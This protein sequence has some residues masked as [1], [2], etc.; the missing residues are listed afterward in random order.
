MLT[1]FLDHV[2]SFALARV[3]ITAIELDVFWHLEQT[4]LTRDNL[5]HRLAIMD[6]PIADAFLD[7][8]VAFQIIAEENDRLT[9][10]PLGKSVLSVYETIK[11]WNK[12]MSLFYSCLNDLT[13]VLRSGR[14]QDSVLSDYWIY[15][16]S[17]K[18]KKLQLSAVDDYSS[19]MDASQVQLS[20]NIVEHYDFSV[21]E[22]IIDFGGGYGGL[23][24]TLAKR[25]HNLRII[26]ADLPAVCDGARARVDTAGL[27]ARI[28]Y[29]PVDFFCDDLPTSVADAIIFERILH[30]W[31]DKEVV[32][33]ITRT[34]SCLHE[35]GVA[36][37]VEPMMDENAKPNPSSILSSLMVTLFGGRRR[38]VQ[39]YMRL[40]RS[41]GY[42]ELSWNDLGLSLY[43]MVLA[44]V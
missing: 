9:L 2:K 16:K 34:R 43:K 12:E 4:P 6:T 18:R 14:Y 44:R 27:G 40:M 7:V 17:P 5:K 20:Q 11:S 8:L 13:S 15:K 29:L 32:D 41:A 39:M 21:H 26:I 23:A 1:K 3:L 36:L 37:V 33:L 30:D 10:L 24:I 22:H 35:S 28:K 25:Y 31:N 19:V 38:S 42:A